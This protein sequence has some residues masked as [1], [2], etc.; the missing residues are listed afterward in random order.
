MSFTRLCPV[1]GKNTWT[2]DTDA[3]WCCPSFSFLLMLFLLSFSF[4]HIFFFLTLFCL[5]YSFSFLLFLK[6]LY[7]YI[8]YSPYYFPFFLVKFSLSPSCF[9]F[10]SFS[11]PP[12][13]VVPFFVANFPLYLF[14]FLLS[15]R[16]STGKL[17]QALCSKTHTH[18]HRGMCYIELYSERSRSFP[19]S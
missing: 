15:S 13:F 14:Y 12:F 17:V 3:S 2:P 8:I 10:F 9:S 7:I 11:I 19:G 18:T 1:R 5:A 4:F 16:S 6:C